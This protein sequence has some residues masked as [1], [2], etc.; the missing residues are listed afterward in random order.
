MAAPAMRP[1]G[2]A[3]AMGTAAPSEVLEAAALDLEE[4]PLVLVDSSVDLVL[5]EV[6]VAVAEELFA[7]LLDLVT[8]VE[9]PAELE[10]VTA[11][12]DSAPL[13]VGVVGASVAVP[14]GITG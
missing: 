6:S 7:A 13:P 3:V 5:V 8:R 11:P 10:P 12:E 4:E 14:E 2:P 1:R 9:E